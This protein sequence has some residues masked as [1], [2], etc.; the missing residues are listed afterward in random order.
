MTEFTID[1]RDVM[2]KLFPEPDNFLMV[3]GLA[4]AARDTAAYTSEA[5]NLIA[6]GGAMGAAVSMALGVALSA[7]GQEVA[8]ITGDG[9][10]LMNIGALVTVA[11]MMPDNLSIVCL[12]NGCHGETGGQMGHTLRRT[13]LALMAEGAGIPSILTVEKPDQLEAAAKFLVDAP[14]PRFLWIRV[15]NGPPADY[16]RNW[17][18][19]ECRLRFRAAYLSGR[20]QSRGGPSNGVAS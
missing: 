4:G 2:P 9:E 3:A 7:P 16:K 6:L 1:R 10:L 8:V 20:K 18:L 12:D 5:H 15:M 11:S 14:A 17:D 19:A 13:N